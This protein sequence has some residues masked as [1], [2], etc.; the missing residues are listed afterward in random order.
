[1]PELVINERDLDAFIRSRKSLLTGGLDDKRPQAWAQYGYP[2]H[3]SPELL[4]QAFERIGEA[5]GAIRAVHERCWEDWPR[6]KLK[7]SDAESPW[8]KKLAELF[9]KVD[10]WIKIQ[11]WDLRNMVGRYSGLILRLADGRPLREPVVRRQG[12]RLVDLVP[13]YETQLEVGSW[14]SDPDSETFGQPLMWRYRARDLRNVDTKGQPDRWVDVHPDR[15]LILAEGSVGNDF[16][17]GRPFLL[18]SYNAL[19]DVEKVRGGSAEGYLKNSARNIKFILDKDADVAKIAGTKED[20]S[21]A[22]AADLGDAVREKMHRINTNIDAGIVGQG[23]DVGV[24]ETTQHDPEP[25]YR[26]AVTGVSAGSGVPSTMLVGQQEGRLASDEDKDAINRRCKARRNKLLSSA[27]RSVVRRLQAVGTLEPSDFE[28]EWKPLDAPGEKD[29]VALLVQYTQ[30][31]KSYAETTATPL[32]GG[33]ELRGVVDFEPR[34]AGGLPGEGDPADDADLD[35]LDDPAPT[36]APPPPEP[37]RT[38]AAN[39]DTEGLFRRF[40]H[41]LRRAA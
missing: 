3:V 5:A 40:V 13:V 20:G 21:P 34:P 11:D 23:A 33:D 1:M 38:T 2:D 10:A 22:T 18:S 16:M 41:W 32:F 29:K 31:N 30:A 6:V 25:A 35:P 9:D 12:M 37:R 8:E 14:D 17:S 26:V 7:A 15:V 19:I 39:D 36:P 24:L 27:V 28:I 4:L